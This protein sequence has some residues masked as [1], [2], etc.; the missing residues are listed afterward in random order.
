M[1]SDSYAR[2]SGPLAKAGAAY[3]KIMNHSK[4]DDRLI[5]VYSDIAKK[6]ELHTHLKSDNGVMKM[7]LIDKGIEI[8]AMKE[9]ALVRGGEHIMF[10][11]LKEPFE[12]GKIIPVTLLFEKAGEVNIEVVVDQKRKEKKHSQSH[13][14]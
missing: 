6:T 10:M 12:N 8:G 3:M 5:S 13:T 1:V 11:G 4:K 9:H 2:S 7:L 14:H